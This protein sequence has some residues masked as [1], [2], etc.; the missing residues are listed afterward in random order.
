VAGLLWLTVALWPSPQKEVR[1]RLH[2]LA[3]L[4][5]V[6]AS[7][8][9]LARLATA[10]ELSNLFATNAVVR[11]DIQ[12]GPR[13]QLSGR[14]EIFQAALG[15]RL[16]IGP[17]HVEFIDVEVQLSGDRQTATVEATGKATQP[18]VRDVF[19]QELKFHFTLRDSGWVIESVETVRTLTL[20]NRGGDAL[21]LR[22]PS[23]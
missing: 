16:T 6:G 14:D 2:Q 11:V 18:G 8:G 13:G 4:A 17:L 5:S 1:K 7:E 12:G 15:A 9:D 21:A 10:R 22:L 20:Q 3:V 19:W 23:A